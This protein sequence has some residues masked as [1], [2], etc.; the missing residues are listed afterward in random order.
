MSLNSH[1]ISHGYKPTLQNNFNKYHRELKRILGTEKYNN[2]R[3]AFSSN[4]YTGSQIFNTFINGDEELFKTVMSSQISYSL[5][6]F[7]FI[8][9]LIDAR[10][11][12]S[13]LEFGGADGWACD[14]I[15]KHNSAKECTVID[16]FDSFKNTPSTITHLQG[17]GYNYEFGKK[18][19]FI[20]SL[21][22]VES[23]DNERFIDFLKNNLKDGGFAA[24]T[25]KI[26]D[27]TNLKELFKMICEA[28]L[29]FNPEL[30][31]LLNLDGRLLPIIVLHKIGSVS[32]PGE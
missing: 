9:N 7:E 30:S 29:Y 5:E 21:F 19:D 27:K 1:L 31:T 32:K 8:L 25:L 24:Y 15:M 2:F 16:L 23:Y 6:T 18:F 26:S 20:F 3:E 14:Y 12:E 22:G 4:M 13:I 11:P 28:G 10:Q 17:D